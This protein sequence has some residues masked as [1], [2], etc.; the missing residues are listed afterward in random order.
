MF[1]QR[2]YKWRKVHSLQWV[3][4]KVCTQ[5]LNVKIPAGIKD[6]TRIKVTGEGNAGKNGE[7]AGIYIL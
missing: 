7:E 6:G 4:A 2:I 3:L 5:K 1:G